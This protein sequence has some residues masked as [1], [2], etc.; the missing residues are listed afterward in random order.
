M[1]VLPRNIDKNEGVGSV[2]VGMTLM[3]NCGMEATVI[4]D[5]GYKNITIQ[6]EDGVIRKHRAKDKFLNGKIAH[7]YDKSEA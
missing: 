5:F 6:F 7:R 1:P 2:C 3:M 4:E